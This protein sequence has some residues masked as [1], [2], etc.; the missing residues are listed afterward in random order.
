MEPPTSNQTRGHD[1]ETGRQ[2]LQLSGDSGEVLAKD[3]LR[4]PQDDG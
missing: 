4:P 3:R 1:L 2:I